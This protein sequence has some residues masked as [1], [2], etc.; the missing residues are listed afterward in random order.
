[1]L[2]II[3]VEGL[4]LRLV[5]LLIVVILIHIRSMIKQTAV[6]PNFPPHCHPLFFVLCDRVITLTS[7]TVAYFL[8]NIS[9][10]IGLLLP[11]S[12]P[13]ALLIGKWQPCLLLPQKQKVWH[14]AKKNLL[15]HCW[16]AT[17]S[18]AGMDVFHVCTCMCL[19]C[20]RKQ[21]F[22]SQVCS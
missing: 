21:L 9:I 2:V 4:S 11:V 1:M 18:L 10:M 16:S 15:S 14:N 7:S 13:L 19:W 22:E 8:I 6:M 12:S 17:N 20:M 5:F 3:K